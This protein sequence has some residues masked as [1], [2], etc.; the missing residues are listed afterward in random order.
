MTSWRIFPAR[1][2]GA[3][4]LVTSLCLVFAVL[5]RAEAARFAVIAQ[6]NPVAS[7]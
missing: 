1:F 4:V 5:P 6:M 3:L 2:R 7:G